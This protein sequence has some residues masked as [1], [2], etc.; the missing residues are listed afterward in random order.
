MSLPDKIPTPEKK[1]MPGIKQYMKLFSGRTDC[2]GLNQLCLKEPLTEEIYE[3]HLTGVKR[4]GVYPIYDRIW[5]KWFACDIDVEDFG[6]ALSIKNQANDYKID[7]YIEKSKSKGYHVFCFFKEPI[8][9][10][11]VR[12]VFEMILEQL[13]INCEMFPKQDEVKENQFGNFIFLPLFGGDTKNNKTVFVDDNNKPIMTKANELKNLNFVDTKVIN[14]LIEI[15]E[16]GRKK[17]IFKED[18]GNITRQTAKTLPCIEKLKQG[19]KI[20]Y[21]NEAAFRIAIFY[22]ERGLDIEEVT[23]LLQNWGAKQ[24]LPKD[25]SARSIAHELATVVKSVYKGGYKSYGCENGLILEFCD[26]ANCPMIQSQ[27]RKEKINQGVITMVFRDKEVMVFRKKEYE[28]RL[29]GFEFTN[30][31]KFKVSLTLSKEDKILFKD[32]IKLGMASNRNRFVKAADDKEID[33]DLIQIEDLVKKQLEQEEHDKLMTPKQLYIMTEQ[34]KNEA[35]KYL[36]NTPDLLWKTIE[37]TNRMGVVGEEIVRLMVYLCFTSRIMSDPL[38]ITIKGEASSGKSFSCQNIQR[39]IPEEG[40]HFITRATANA[41]FHLAEDGMKHRIIYINELPGSESADYSIRTAQSEG[42]LILMMPV[43]DPQTGNMETITKK[44]SGPVGFLITTTKAQMFDENETRNFSVYSDDSPQ[45]TTAIG[46][47]TV[48]KALGEEFSVD[49]TELNLLKNIQRLLNP[50]FKV[51]IPYAKEVFGNFPDKPVRIRRDRERFRVLI[52]IITVLHQFHREQ[53]KAKDGKM[54]L[55]STLSDYLLAKM[56]AEAT[57]TYTIYEIGPAS[58]ELWKTIKQM[59]TNYRQ[60][61]P[62]EIGEYGFKYKDVADYI[63]W[64]VDKV[65][66]WMYVLVKAGLLEYTER[67]IGGKGKA[68]TFKVSTRGLEWSSESLGFLPPVEDLIAKYPC[69]EK[70]FY[71]PITGS[72]INPVNIDAPEGLLDD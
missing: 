62:E 47:I 60:N 39:L 70:L 41:F 7:M 52:E 38:S 43:K 6:I 11:K 40:Y 1:S 65:K 36:E 32:L 30:A 2:Y 51:I 3:Q 28:Y 64:K 26:K 44:V 66:K 18:T 24:S 8:E 19:V 5:C 9:A 13:D 46:D 21:R 25:K 16:L 54:H 12:L 56:V 33:S 45:L 17:V 31:G 72:A 63:G 37:I 71:N 42:D 61:N 27:N 29:S 55:I 20:G 59:D 34:E 48:R 69:D 58:E 49:E 67:G 10:I 68:S 50:D 53:V 14:E 57:L 4:I 35:I 15:N 23:S 22:K